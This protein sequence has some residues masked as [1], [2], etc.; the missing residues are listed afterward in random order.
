MIEVEKQLK[1][2]IT[3][4]NGL[5]EE[6]ASVEQ[7]LEEEGEKKHSIE[8]CNDALMELAITNN[9]IGQIIKEKQKKQK[10]LDKVAQIFLGVVTITILVAGL[11]FF[12][13]LIGGLLTLLKVPFFSVSLVHIGIIFAVTEG[14]TLL[15]FALALVVSNKDG[16]LAEQIKV[17]KNDREENLTKYRDIVN[18]KR[19]LMDLT[20][21]TDELEDIKTRQSYIRTQ[22][23]CNEEE[24][25]TTLQNSKTEND[26]EYISELRSSFNPRVLM[27]ED[28]NPL[29]QKHTLE[30]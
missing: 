15:A 4:I 16:K 13:S 19:A 2:L 27:I 3:E 29:V 14:V 22:I 30:Q 8:K 10:V 26:T 18:Q 1:K 25:W 12:G 23:A 28:N 11:A 5:E 7:L 20:L 6:M 9:S 21:S 17:L 24:I